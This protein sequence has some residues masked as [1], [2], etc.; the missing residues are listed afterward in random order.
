MKHLADFSI[1]ASKNV[2]VVFALSIGAADDW[3]SSEPVPKHRLDDLRLAKAGYGRSKL[4]G[5]LILDTATEHY[6]APTASVR[7]GQIAEPKSEKGTWNPKEFIPSLIASSV[8]LGILPDHLGPQQKVAW[9]PVED[10]AELILDLAGVT[11]QRPYLR[12]LG[13][14]TASIHLLPIGRIS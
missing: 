4:I 9:I 5:S 8:H 2:P 3:L 11:T 12:Y 14:S 10:T 1:A 13:I 7:V 6:G